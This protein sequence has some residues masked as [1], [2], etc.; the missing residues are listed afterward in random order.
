M[1]Q[2]LAS[3]L[4]L[5]ALLG[6]LVAGSVTASARTAVQQHEQGWKRAGRQLHRLRAEH[7]RTVQRLRSD[8][9][10]A[11]ELLAAGGRGNLDRRS[12]IKRWGAREIRQTERLTVRERRTFRHQVA[13]LTRTRRSNA[14]W[15]DT[16][17]VFEWCPVPGYSFIHDDFGEMVRMPGIPRHI[18]T[19][20]D[21]QAPYGSRIVA[22]FDGRAVGSASG[23]GGLEVRVYGARGYVYN[24]HLAWFGRLGY[25]RAGD[26]IGYVGSTGSSTAPH[27]HIE[28]HPGDGGAVDPHLYLAMSCIG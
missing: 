17:A 22:P 7:R 1:K 4:F 15:L 11:R 19:G 13:R 24:A 23:L 16:Y 18:H 12:G 3:R 2:P 27:D 5:L 21:V 8:A 25:V 28:W 6:C 9:L 26:T 14:A 10:H 20:S